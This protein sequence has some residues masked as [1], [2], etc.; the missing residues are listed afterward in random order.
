MFN[1]DISNVATKAESIAKNVDLGDSSKWNGENYRDIS[2]LF[3][4][5]I[6]IE[7]Q[8]I[9]KIYTVEEDW[10]DIQ[11]QIYL[12]SQEIAT[13]VG[14]LFNWS[15]DCFGWAKIGVCD[16]CIRTNFLNS[17]Q[18]M[19]EGTIRYENTQSISKKKNI[20]YL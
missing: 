13:A 12:E 2:N 10:H 19:K 6:G 17:K 11:L 8:T 9:E 15:F 18:K 20:Q 5:L 7:C 4:P 1:C 14:I 16:K 3:K